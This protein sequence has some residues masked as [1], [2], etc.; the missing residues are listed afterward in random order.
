MEKIL[1]EAI[2]DAGIRKSFLNMVLLVQERNS[3]LDKWEK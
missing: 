3:N 2:P 1:G